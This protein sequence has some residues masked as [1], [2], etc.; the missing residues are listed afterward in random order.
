MS[1]PVLEARALSSGY[2]PVPVLREIDLHV[3]PGT[4]WRSWAPTEPARRRRC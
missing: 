1:A 2:G 3:A 4:L